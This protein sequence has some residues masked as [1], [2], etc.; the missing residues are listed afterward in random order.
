ML[1]LSSIAHQYAYLWSK[2][3]PAILKLMKDAAHGPQE[4]KLS[5]HEFHNVNSTKKGGFAF[6][7]KV[8]KSKAINNI[9][10]SD[11][12][13]DLLL[14]L[15]RSETATGL[16]ENLVYEFTLDKNFVLHIKQEGPSAV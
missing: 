13:K 3:R 6:E 7:L 14:I 2:Y 12:A 5:N 10:D 15:G 11:I 8:F 16:T 9:R 4:Y 1:Y